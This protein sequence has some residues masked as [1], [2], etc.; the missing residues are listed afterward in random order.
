MRVS[1]AVPRG[2]Y[3]LR[4]NASGRIGEHLVENRRGAVG[5]PLFAV[6]WVVPANAF[7]RVADGAT[8]AD[9]RS[10]DVLAYFGVVYVYSVQLVAPA[11]G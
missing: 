3:G 1:P 5:D 9:H 2:E 10:A 11:D 8:W 6:A 7:L 4:G